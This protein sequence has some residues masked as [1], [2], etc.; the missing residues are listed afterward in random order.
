MPDYSRFNVVQKLSKFSLLD[1]GTGWVWT[2]IRKY[3]TVLAMMN[4][5]LSLVVE[6]DPDFRKVFKTD[7]YQRIVKLTGEEWED[8]ITADS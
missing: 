2:S 8:E 1:C 5:I 4:H 7:G 6:D 3:D